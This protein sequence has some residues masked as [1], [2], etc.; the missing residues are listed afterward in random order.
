MRSLSVVVPAY[1]EATRLPPTLDASLAYLQ[2][3]PRL[4][5]LIVVDDGSTDGTASI[6][7]QRVSAEPRGR[8]RLLRA[9][10]NGGKGAALRAGA[11]AARGDRILLV[12][13]DGATPLSALPALERALDAEGCGVAVGS[14]SAVLGRRPAY[15]QLMGTVFSALASSCVAEL[16]D[17]QCGFKLLTRP[18]AERTFPHLHLAGWAYDVEL[19]FL[20]QQLGLGVTSAQVP[21][22]D[23]AGSKVRLETPLQMAIDVARVRLLYAAGVW[24]LPG[25]DA[26][27]PQPQR[28]ELMSAPEYVEEDDPGTAWS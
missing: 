23:V 10:R 22:R 9:E 18:A 21:W 25:Q 12:D 17:T 13:A 26:S 16:D 5:E 4:W 19:L 15:R 7:Q 2:A 14:R 8:V 3:E 24:R 11:S 1:N 6:V 28:A 20:A 27:S